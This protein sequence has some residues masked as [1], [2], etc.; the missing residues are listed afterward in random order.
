MSFFGYT[1]I[2]PPAYDACLYASRIFA[3]RKLQPCSRARG[4]Y[5][6]HARGGI[7]RFAANRG[8]ARFA[9]ARGG[10]A[11]FAARR[12]I[13]MLRDRNHI[14][15]QVK[16]NLTDEKQQSQNVGRQLCDCC[17]LIAY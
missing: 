1:V 17:I 10:I 14:G 4:R 11:R 9:C 5:Q 7:S 3:D 15:N 6:V 8:I 12:G 2:D 16:R 13:V